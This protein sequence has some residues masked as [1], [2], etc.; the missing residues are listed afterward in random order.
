LPYNT[1]LSIRLPQSIPC[2]ADS[3]LHALYSYLGVEFEQKKSQYFCDI[4]K[5]SDKITVCTIIFSN[6]FGVG[7]RSDGF[8]FTQ[9]LIY[10]TDIKRPRFTRKT[11]YRV[12]V[13]G[14]FCRTLQEFCPFKGFYSYEL[15][16][17]PASA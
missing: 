1:A 13:I 10:N 5:I 4:S 6:L 16:F 3:G 17:F 11:D 12:L 15:N 14:C 8:R 7:C 2:R 9:C